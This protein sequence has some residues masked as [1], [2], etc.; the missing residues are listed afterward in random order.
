MSVKEVIKSLNRKVYNEH[1]VFLFETDK[2]Q[3]SVH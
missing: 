1:V 3:N 2:I